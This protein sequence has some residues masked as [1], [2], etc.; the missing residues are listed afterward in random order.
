MSFVDFRR[1]GKWE[2]DADWSK[3]RG[4]C[5]MFDY[6]NFRQNIIDNLDEPAFKNKPICEVMLNQKYFNGMDK[7]EL[8]FANP[9][10]ILYRLNKSLKDDRN[11]VRK[12]SISIQSKNSTIC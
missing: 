11:N 8:F 5:P 12:K 9:T 3:D 4:P 6:D 2:V 7:V 1:F 10:E